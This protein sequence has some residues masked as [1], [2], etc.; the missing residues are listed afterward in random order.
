MVDGMSDRILRRALI[1]I[2]LAAL[3]L[4]I[5][6]WFTGR[7]DIATRIHDGDNNAG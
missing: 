6:A 2:A 5:L 3:N 7:Q 1:V 4:G